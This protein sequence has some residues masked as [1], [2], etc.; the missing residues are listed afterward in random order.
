MPSVQDGPSS[1]LFVPLSLKGN[2]ALSWSTRRAVTAL[3]GA[4]PSRSRM[5]WR[6]E[7]RPY[8]SS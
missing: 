7:I 2:V 3:V 6:S 1:P 4:F 5:S 8:P